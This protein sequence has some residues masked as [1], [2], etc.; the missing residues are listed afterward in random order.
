MSQT[1]DDQIVNDDP[2]DPQTQIAADADPSAVQTDPE[3]HPPGEPV[4]SR[5]PAAQVQ[6]TQTREPAQRQAPVY[7]P[8]ERLV[9][10]R[11]AASKLDERFGGDG[12]LTET[13]GAILDTTEQLAQENASL[14]VQLQQQGQ[15]LNGMGFWQQHD[16]DPANR[17]YPSSQAR[18]DYQRIQGEVASDPEYAGLDDNTRTLAIQIAAKERFAHLAQSKRGGSAANNA[19]EQQQQAAGQSAAVQQTQVRQVGSTRAIPRGTR[20]VPP[21]PARRMTVTEMLAGGES[22]MPADLKARV[23]Q[24]FREMEK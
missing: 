11:Q 23:E 3:A 12:Q 19:Q 16:S 20:T 9:R 15:S 6:P 10:A 14:R 7:Q 8:P 17:D 13:L 22:A 18:Q 1:A 2:T 4:D 5:P 24:E 21:P